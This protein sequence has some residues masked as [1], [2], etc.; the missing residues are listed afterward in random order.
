MDITEA[1]IVTHMGHIIDW[2]KGTL[3][4]VEFDFLRIWNYLQS[5]GLYK[6]E[7]LHF[8]HVHPSGFGVNP[9]YTDLNC[10][11]GLTLALGFSFPF[12]IIEF[13]ENPFG[14]W[15]TYEWDFEEKNIKQLYYPQYIPDST[16][17]FLKR[18]SGHYF[19]RRNK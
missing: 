11:E 1:S 8:I 19:I 16:C 14:N 13:G 4:S 5:I 12:S 3:C 6:K 15:K 9:S 7:W 17:Y 18:L 10:I 2:Q